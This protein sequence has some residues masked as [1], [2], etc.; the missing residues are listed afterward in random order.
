MTDEPRDEPPGEVIAAVEGGVRVFWVTAPTMQDLV[1]RLAVVLGEHT[2][3]DDELHITYNAMQN[4]W[5]E[6]PP[7]ARRLTK[8][9]S[10]AGPSCTSSTAHSS[11]YVSSRRPSQPRRVRPAHCGIGAPDHGPPPCSAAC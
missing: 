6:H 9:P 1:S 8:P 7:Q 10:R 2:G 5:Q 4:G 3:D 11:S